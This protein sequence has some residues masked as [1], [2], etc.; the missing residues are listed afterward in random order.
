LDVLLE[1]HRKT[2]IERMKAHPVVLCPQNTT[3][4][5]YSG[6]PDTEGLGPSG[7]TREEPRGFSCTI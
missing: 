5:D 4:L 1:P 6:H 7:T 3:E 2:T